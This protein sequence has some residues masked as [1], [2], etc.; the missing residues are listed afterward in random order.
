MTSAFAPSV[1]R[2]YLLALS[3][4][5]P[6]RTHSARGLEVPEYPEYPIE[7]PIEYLIEYSIEHPIEYPSNRAR[8]ASVTRA[9]PR[10]L[11]SVSTRTIG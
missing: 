2:A 11:Y 1:P 9:D 4:A 7:Y 3:P 10:G 5:G 6:N 8:L